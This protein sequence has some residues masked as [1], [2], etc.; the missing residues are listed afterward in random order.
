MS[1]ARSPTHRG[2]SARAN[3][4]AFLVVLGHALSWLAVALPVLAHG[5]QLV[6]L[7][8]CVAGATIVSVCAGVALFVWS[9][10]RGWALLLSVIAVPVTPALLYLALSRAPWLGLGTLFV[11]VPASPILVALVLR[12]LLAVPASPSS[13]ATH[14]A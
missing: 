14:H 6:F 1:A 10:V 4:R 2:A 8:L 5:E 7:M 11:A 3:P 13:G 9:R 12:A